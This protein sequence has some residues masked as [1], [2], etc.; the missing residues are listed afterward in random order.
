MFKDGL[1]NQLDL[2]NLSQNI[3]QNIAFLSRYLHIHK[4]MSMHQIEMG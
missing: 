4:P 1:L 3:S 2:I